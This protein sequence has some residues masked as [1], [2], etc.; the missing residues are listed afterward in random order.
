MADLDNENTGLGGGSG[1]KLLAVEHMQGAFSSDVAARIHTRASL[2]RFQPGG[3]VGDGLRAVPASLRDD[4][5]RAMGSNGRID[6][7]GEVGRERTTL[8]LVVKHVRAALLDQVQAAL[9]AVPSEDES[10]TQYMPPSIA[11]KLAS[12]AVAG[13][14]NVVE[15]GRKRSMF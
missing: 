7:A 10:G 13:Q 4:L 15:Y 8:P 14:F 6:A 3:D 12:A 5:A 1:A 9:M 2:V 11:L